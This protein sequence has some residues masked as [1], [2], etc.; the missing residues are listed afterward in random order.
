MPRKKYTYAKVTASQSELITERSEWE[1]EWRQISDY[2]LP[3]RGIYQTYNK[4]RKRKLTTPNIINSVGEDSLTVLTSGMH[5]RLT[6]PA[7]PWFRLSWGDGRLNVIEQTKAWLQQAGD[8][9][10]KG[11]H[12]S[13][14]YSI[15]NSF[16]TEYAGFGTGS[17]YV[18][19]DTYDDYIPFRFELL[20]AGEYAFSIGPDGKPAVYTRTIFLTPRQLVAQFPKTASKDVKLVVSENRAGADTTYLTVLEY[21]IKEQYKGMDYYMIRYELSSPGSNQSNVSVPDMTKSPLSEDGFNEHPYPTARWNTI[22]SD[23]YGIGPGS[24]ALPDIKRLQEMEKA[25]LMATHK[26]INPPLNAPARMKGKLNSLPGGMNYYA[27]PQE[28]V[29]EL[30]QIKFDYQGVSAAVERVEERI[31]RNFYNDVFLTATRD[32]NASPLKATQVIAQEQ[33][34][35]FRLGPVVE[36]LGSEFFTPIIGRSF[37]IMHRKGMFPPLAPEFEDAIEDMTITLISPMA[38]A[39]RTVKSQGVDAFMGFIGQA[40]Q[41]DPTIVDNLDSDEAAR[42]RADIEGVDIGILR[43]EAEVKKIRD[44]RAKA[45]AREQQKQD[46]LTAQNMQNETGPAGAT[47]RKTNAEAGQVLAETQLTAQQ[48]GLL[49]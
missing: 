4:P 25:F 23:T 26:S 42:Q 12:I 16:Y 38:I 8:L 15:I 28:T 46:A 49:Q 3:G 30:Y 7:M 41:F 39:Q 2:L 45:E 34:K 11:L 40:A 9:L 44:D 1:A 35:M 37:H 6:S 10:H 21:L 20:T 47:T 14:F 36:R 48:S 31:Q 18:G 43:P 19:E 22:G 29:N 32:P 17:M 13:N 24:R 27:N 33:E 5:G